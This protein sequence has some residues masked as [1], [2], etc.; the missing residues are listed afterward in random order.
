MHVYVVSSYLVRL[1][2]TFCVLCLSIPN[3]CFRVHLVQW[4]LHTLIMLLFF[5]IASMC[6]PPLYIFMAVFRYLNSV[7]VSIKGPRMLTR[8]QEDYKCQLKSYLD[9][10]LL[11]LLVMKPINRVKNRRLDNH[12][13]NHYIVCEPTENG[14]TTSRRLKDVVTILKKCRRLIQRWDDS[15]I[16]KEEKQNTFYVVRYWRHYSVGNSTV[17]M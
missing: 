6:R 14:H 15:R 2:T 3:L 9:Q 7:V 8:I 11:H 12:P 1:V 16:V 4:K 17:F 10:L 5:P 13:E